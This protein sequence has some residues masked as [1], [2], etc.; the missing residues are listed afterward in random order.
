MPYPDTQTPVPSNFSEK[1]FTDLL[2]KVSILSDQVKT[3]YDEREKEKKKL[4]RKP[5]GKKRKAQTGERDVGV[6]KSGISSAQVSAGENV[7][8]SVMGSWPYSGEH[9]MTIGQ[10]N[11]VF[12]DS[13]GLVV[14]VV[15]GDSAITSNPS[16]PGGPIL[17]SSFTPISIVTQPIQASENIPPS[18]PAPINNVPPIPVPEVP[19]PSA[20]LPREPSPVPGP[21]QPRLPPKSPRSV[22]DSSDGYDRQTDYSFS[23]DENM[24]ESKD[25][26]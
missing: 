2:S 1:I 5:R 21:S 8:V 12:L 15:Q 16:I 9:G 17:T 23:G 18:I 14:P 24:K 25:R 22:Q 26:N 6:T 20:P 10:G 3:L 11:S 4:S 7:S 13:R 19:T